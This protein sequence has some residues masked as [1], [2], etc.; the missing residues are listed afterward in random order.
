MTDLEFDILDE[1]YFVTSFHE[2]EKSTDKG[3]AE[4]LFVLKTLLE[5]GWIKCF[6]DVTEEITATE[7][8]FSNNYKNYQYLAT[9]AGLLA[10]NG[11][12]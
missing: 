7:K 1:L 11:R 2:L 6:K 4:I 5:K 3:E 12:G 9:K 10:H 8:D